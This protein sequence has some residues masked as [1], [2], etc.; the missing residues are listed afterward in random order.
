MQ[1]KRVLRSAKTVEMAAKK[2]ETK[3]ETKETKETKPVAEPPA[4]P[5]VET[6]DSLF[7]D[8]EKAPEL[9]KTRRRCEGRRRM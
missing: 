1:P 2:E 8:E 4:E 3:E 7:D 6:E 5:K 9:R